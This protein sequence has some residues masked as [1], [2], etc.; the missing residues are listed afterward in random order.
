M[1]T[2]YNKINHVYLKETKR[3]VTNKCAKLNFMIKYT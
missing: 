3:N 1:G 2:E